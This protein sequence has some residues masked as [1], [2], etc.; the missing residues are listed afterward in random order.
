[1]ALAS[2]DRFLFARRSATYDC[3]DLVAEV[4]EAHT[5]EDIRERLGDLLGA[6][7]RQIGKARTSF[8]RLARPEDPCIAVMHSDRG[9][10]HVG[11]YLRGRILHLL[12]RSPEFME[13]DVAARGFTRVRYFR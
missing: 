7:G 4:W 9:D 12:G 6:D 11:V 5:G 2:I 3:L 8:T 1:M 10:P 13:P